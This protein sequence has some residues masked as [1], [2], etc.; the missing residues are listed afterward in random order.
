MTAQGSAGRRSQ[1]SSAGDE[2]TQDMLARVAHEL[3]SP[4]T[5]LRGLAETMKNHGPRLGEDRTRDVIDALVRQSIYAEAILGSL[6]E[7][8]AIEEGDITAPVAPFSLSALASHVLRAQEP[9]SGTNVTV[10]IPEDLMI[11]ADGLRMEQV[12]RNLL[13]N[14]YLHGGPRVRVTAYGIN[15]HVTLA[16]EDDGGGVPSYLVSALFDPFTR[17]A[18]EDGRVQGTGLG[19]SISQ[20]IVESCGGSLT[21]EPAI[22]HGSR[23]VVRLPRAA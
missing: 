17:G 14:A 20:R 19:L 4:L 10:S 23:F 7:F 1:F 16:V 5:V 15:R 8:A 9:P 12:L 11:S 18:V 6:E 21:Y 22:P 3:R 2:H 13:R